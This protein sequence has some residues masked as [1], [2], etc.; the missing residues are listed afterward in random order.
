MESS[1]M[2]VKE[3]QKFCWEDC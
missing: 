3:L 2:E 1:T